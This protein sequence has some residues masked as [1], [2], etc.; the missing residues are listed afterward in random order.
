MNCL[1]R[2]DV[3]HL[4][5]ADCEVK[6]NNEE[7][8]EYY[9]CTWLDLVMETR[10]EHNTTLRESDTSRR[11]SYTQQQV[12]HFLAQRSPQQKICLGRQGQ[13]MEEYQLPYRNVLPVPIFMPSNAM[14]LKEVRRVP[15]P[16]E[17]R[18]AIALER[19]R[20]SGVCADKTELSHITRDMPKVVQPRRVEFRV[21]GLM[22]PPGESSHHLQ[23]RY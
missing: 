20:S 14:S 2:K 9:Q 13:K 8:R 3:F 18:A 11:E 16:D 12:A 21:S 22:S 23:G 15:T 10:P 5:N 7:H 1:S 4:V 19:E 17:L 6:E